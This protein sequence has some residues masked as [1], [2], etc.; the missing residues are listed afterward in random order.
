LADEIKYKAMIIQC[1]SLKAM[2]IHYESLKAQCEA[3][4]LLKPLVM[5]S[6]PTVA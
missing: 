1:E 6:N 3:A 5:E 2:S 4:G